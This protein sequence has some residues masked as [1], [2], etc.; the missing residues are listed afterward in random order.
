[1]IKKARMKSTEKPRLSPTNKRLTGAPPIADDDP[2]RL[3]ANQFT[4]KQLVSKDREGRTLAELHEALMNACADLLQHP[5]L[6]ASTFSKYVY[7]KVVDLSLSGAQS[8]L[9]EI[10]VI[11][12]KSEMT[13]ITPEQAAVIGE[14]IGKKYSGSLPS[15]LA[16]HR[17]LQ[18]TYRKLFANV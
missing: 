3:W 12:S 10:L 9:W 13:E 4:R 18:S 15:A 7:R 5:S 1:M 8:I 6:S 11:V 17:E 14:L 16:R 2:I